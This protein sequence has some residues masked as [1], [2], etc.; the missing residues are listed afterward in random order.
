MKDNEEREQNSEL[1]PSGEVSPVKPLSRSAELEFPLE[2]P[3]SMGA[4]SGA[5]D[6]KDPLGAEAA[7]GALGSPPCCPSLDSPSSLQ[8]LSYSACVLPPPIPVLST[9]LA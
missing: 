5:L 2:E 3:D 7:P 1:A 4:D 9:M 8:G 6:E